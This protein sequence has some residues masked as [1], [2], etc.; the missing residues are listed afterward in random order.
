MAAAGAANYADCVGVHYNAGATSPT[1]SSGHSGGSHYSW[2]YTPMVNLYYN[3][4]GGSRKLCFTELGYLSGE[5]F[6]GISDAFGWARNT[7][8]AQHAQW[9]AEAAS[10]GASSGRVRLMIVFNVDF[11]TYDP[12]GD[13][14]AGY[15]MIR[16]NGSCPSCDTLHAVTGGR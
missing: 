2:Y 16:P 3:A 6:P 11:T 13:P 14:Q 9:R 8:L 10:L 7:S 15:A 12:G 4:F 5:G 1:T